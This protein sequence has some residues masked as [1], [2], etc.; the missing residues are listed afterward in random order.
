MMRTTFEEHDI[1]DGNQPGGRDMKKLTF[2][3]QI[4]FGIALAILAGVLTS[5][6]HN[7]IFFNAAWVIYGLLF[8]AHPVYPERIHEEKGKLGARIAGVLCVAMGLMTRFGV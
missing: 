7:G 6:C 4:A 2:K 5:V 8:L 1:G 3:K